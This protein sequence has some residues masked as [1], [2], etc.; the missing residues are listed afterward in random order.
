VAAPE[1]TEELNRLRSEREAEEKHMRSLNVEL[2]GLEEVKKNQAHPLNLVTVKRA[3]TPVLARAGEESRV[4]FKA[5]MNDEFEFLDAQGEWIHVQISGVSRGYIRRSALELPEVIAEHLEE[6]AKLEA[7]AKAVAFRVEREENSA[8]P[9]DWEALKGK[10]VKIF[11]VQPVS[12][13]P[14]ETD[15]RAKLNFAGALMR[16]F[17]A[18]VTPGGTAAD[19]VVV[20][21]DSADGGIAGATLASIQQIAKEEISEEAFWKQCYLDPPETFQSQR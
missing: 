14:K 11:T 15:A 12:Q 17:V 1:G 2:Q 9:G 7:A 10:T 21:F 20:I 19:G 3:G 5:A 13:D 6:T 18:D 8:F 16:K 4:L